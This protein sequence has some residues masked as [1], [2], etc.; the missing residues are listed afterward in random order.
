MESL[1]SSQRAVYRSLVG[2]GLYALQ[3]SRWLRP[4]PS[5]SNP[6]F[7]SRSAQPCCCGWDCSWIGG[8]RAGTAC[9]CSAL[10]TSRGKQT[11]THTHTH[12]HTHKH[13]T[14]THTHTPVTI[15]AHIGAMQ[16]AALL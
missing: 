6:L 4:A 7:E 3:V 11:S 16:R 10:T 2:R 12:A 13:T 1:P 14:H 8:G 5:P 15:A 9:I